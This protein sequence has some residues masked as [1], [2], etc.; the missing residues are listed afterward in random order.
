MYLLA[1]QVH[2]ASIM[3][4]PLS[5]F[6]SRFILLVLIHVATNFDDGSYVVTA[7]N[8]NVILGRLG[9]GNIVG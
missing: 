5:S 1:Y 7:I 3:D 4:L 9:P 6:V 8:K 2:D